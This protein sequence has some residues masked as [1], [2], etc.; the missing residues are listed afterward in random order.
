MATDDEEKLCRLQENNSRKLAQQWQQ[1]N[2][3]QSLQA[4]LFKYWS[5]H[6][7]N[8]YTIDDEAEVPTQDNT[9]RDLIFSPLEW[10]IC[11]GSD[12]K[13]VFKKLKQEDDPP[14]L[15]GRV[16]K[17]GEPTYS[18]RDC[19]VDPTCVFCID[20]FQK[21]AH[22]THRY[23]MSTSGGGG[24]CDCGDVE[25]WK[26]NP[27]CEIHTVNSEQS[28]KSPL[29]RLPAE[30]KSKTE[31]LFHIAL[32]YAYDL[33]IW[34]QCD[35]LPHGLQPSVLADSY[36]TMLFNDEVHTYDQVIDTLKKAVDCTHKEAVD[37]ATVVDREGRSSVCNGNFRIC[38]QACSI[39]KRNTSRH[40]NKALKVHV[41]HTS[42]VAHHTFAM[43]LLSWLTE[44]IAHSEGLRQLLCVECMKPYR[45]TNKALIEHVILS[46]TKL[47]KVA[48]IHWHQLIMSSVLIDQEFK[49]QFAMMYTKNY[50]TL[51]RDFITLDDHDHSVSITSLSVQMFTVPTLSRMLI[52]ECDLLSEV[53]N[54]FMSFCGPDRRAEGRLKFD[55]NSL[56]QNFRRIQYILL[57]LRYIL[58]SIPNE[59]E[60]KLKEKFLKGLNVFLELLSAIQGMDAVTRQVALH[61]EVEPEWETAFNLQIKLGSCI[62]MLLEWCAT[63][64]SVLVEAYRATMKILR[65]ISGSSKLVKKKISGH[66]CSCIVYDVATQP[67]TVHSPLSR[68]LAGLHVSLQ[69]YRISYYSEGFLPNMP[70]SPAEMIEEAM[71]TQVM[72]SQVQAGMWRRNGYS[73][74]NQIYYYHNVRCRSEMQDRDILM[75][76]IGAM[77]MN[78]NEFVITVLNKYGLI[79]V[80][81]ENADKL[82]SEDSQKQVHIETLIEEFLLLLIV[83]LG[84]RYAAGVG[85]VSHEDRVKREV[86]H[87]LCIGPMPH[88]ELAKSLTENHNHETGLETVITSVATFKK[89]GATG[90][91][92]YELKREFYKDYNPFF[93][94]YSKADQ[95]KAEETQRKMKKSNGEGEA[96]PPPVP[97]PFTSTFKSVS[98]VLQC[99]VMIHVLSTI[100][101]RASLSRIRGWTE[102]MIQRVLYLVGMAL[103][104]E[105]CH[106]NNHED[107]GFIAKATA[108]PASVLS[109]LE[110]LAKIKR[111]E[112]HK[113]LLGWVLKTFAEVQQLKGS[114]ITS[115]EV[116]KD[117]D[118]EAEKKRKSELAKQR[119][120][121]IMAQMS[122]MQRNFIK[123]NAELFEATETELDSDV[124]ATAM[125]T[126]EILSDFPVA[127]GAK[128]SKAT[129]QGVTKCTC[130]LCQEDEEVTLDGRAM[131]LASLVQRSTVL[132]K[133]RGKVIG[134]AEK[135]DAMFVPPDLYYGTHVSTC[136]HIMHWDCWQR[137]FE[138][139]VAKEQRRPH[140]FRAHL[141]FDVDKR[142]F[143]CPLC[144]SLSNAV[145]P[146]LP[147]PGTST[148]Q[149]QD[150]IC[151]EK[152][153]SP[154]VSYNEWLAGIQSILQ[155]SQES[156]LRQKQQQEEEM[157]QQQ[158]S[159]ENS[160]SDP[161][162]LPTLTKMMAQTMAQTVAENFQLLFE[163][164]YSIPSQFSDSVKDM[165]KMFARSLYMVGLGLMP[166]DEDERVPVVAWTTCAYTIHSVEN[167]LREE[168][169]P[170]FGSLSSRQNEC[171]GALV[172]FAAACGNITNTTACRKHALRLLSAMTAMTEVA[173]L[174]CILDID[175]F[176]LMVN[177][178]LSIPLLNCEDS[179][180]NSSTHVSGE[181]INHHWALKVT[182][183]AHILQILFTSTFQTSDE[184]ME[185]EDRDEAQKLLEIYKNLHTTAGNKL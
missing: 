79:N 7:P 65:S 174:P 85:Q 114:E 57:D 49:K 113:D 127:V 28:T 75:L 9:G 4:T 20:C 164:V 101:R 33:L 95:S 87:Q 104:E 119:R 156:A 160:L 102:T 12:P 150:S 30:M 112:E 60:S 61:I 73:L 78:P 26:Q 166:F 152:P 70:L 126:S 135:F 120:A 134:D 90:K 56:Q 162:P 53:L 17:M 130:I 128:R 117:L 179:V 50:N 15:C 169:K 148:S 98:S 115:V 103:H 40:G 76:Q 21:S 137:F 105:K 43:R 133:S 116:Q 44:I 184:E 139:V 155:A 138:S 182:L 46:D 22:R 88:S 68:F 99:D 59:W 89:P 163:Y 34:E 125:D 129:E 69:K 151:D 38:E 141:S 159:E 131:V 122:A 3:V 62:T 23:R 92:L 178:C 146:L 172:R 72:I 81:K 6:V 29:E 52:M 84:E 165:I 71:H 64:R 175:M 47:W 168:A 32:N 161:C 10:F 180:C 83:V 132:S 37:F 77:L 96:L 176:T 67:V 24:F 181:A 27:S 145:I 74:L 167:L 136:G 94:H 16:F 170:L 25:A 31:I 143:L 48:R 110:S 80:M 123:E 149:S 158:S 82:S 8:I 107:F 39:I 2:D 66:D 91:G 171:L 97:P 106:H 109:L 111:V 154:E 58:S 13:V 147:H 1:C 173:D 86:I 14:K 19:A 140:R 142:E 41:M 118:A 93:Y 157:Q 54:T 45:D 153:A 11:S 185:L 55:R 177:V 124:S 36:C 183:T 51:Q 5:S 35:T 18:C 100:L 63:D 108:G 121:R 42:V 144:E